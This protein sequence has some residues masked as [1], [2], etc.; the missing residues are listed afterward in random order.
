MN[1]TT[2]PRVALFDQFSPLS[3]A[4]WM[5][6]LSLFPCLL[7]SYLTVMRK[8]CADSSDDDYKKNPFY[9]LIRWTAICD[10]SMHIYTV[11]T[12]LMDSFKCRFLGV[13]FDILFGYLFYWALG[14]YGSQ[15]CNVLVATN[16]FYAILFNVHYRLE[17][18]KVKA[19]VVSLVAVLVSLIIPVP[20]MLHTTFEYFSMFKV[21][22]KSILISENH[23]LF[24]IPNDD[25]FS[26]QYSVT[27]LSNDLYTENLLKLRIFFRDN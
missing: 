14:W 21:S 27:I 2:I 20:I 17:Y 23:L 11:Y 5:I 15:I 1:N 18:T 12:V 25:K 26:W 3:P 4:E 16:R 10:F 9:T 7:I 22:W 8:I 19:R 6:T 24:W 13:K